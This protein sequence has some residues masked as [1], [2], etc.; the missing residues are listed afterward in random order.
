MASICE[1]QLKKYTRIPL[2]NTQ[3]DVDLG[4]IIG[5]FPLYWFIGI[6]QFVWPVL[7]LW[8]VIKII[9]LKKNKLSFPNLLLMFVLFIV[10]QII[11]SIS[12]LFSEELYTWFAFFRNLATFITG[13]FVLFIV[14]NAVQEWEQ[15]KRLIM[16]AT[17]VFGLTALVGMLAIV[18]LLRFNFYSP[19]SSIFPS[20][21]M[22]SSVGGR[23]SL[24]SLGISATLFSFKYYR[25]TTFFSFP[26]L[27]ATTLLPLI[28]LA[29]YT[30]KISKKRFQKILMV[31]AIIFMGINLLFTTSRAATASLIA[32]F[33]YMQV[34]VKKRRK[35]LR[36]SV[37]VSAV[38]VGLIIVVLNSALVDAFKD[39]IAFRSTNT[40]FSL[41][42]TTLNYW[43][44]LPIF[45]WATARRME[46]TGIY[47]PLGSHSYYLAILFRFGLLGSITF[48]LKYVLLWTGTRPFKEK[49]FKDQALAQMDDL[50]Q[51][52]RWIVVALIID[53]FATI[54]ITDMSTMV[55]VWLTFGL[56]YVTRRIASRKK[57]EAQNQ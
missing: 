45:G 49:Q 50:L 53:G 46:E 31:I 30:F 3:P 48:I 2:I 37:V 51:D 43:L 32:G 4:I 52:G 54:P 8:V 11:S 15:V 35:F 1:N 28:P 17:S 25:L 18:G 19:A 47:L 55:F 7:L 6:D 22:E 20:W 41:Y 39:L 40:R 26:T 16:T 23:F 5:L 56:L 33:V 12:A 38:L 27:Y 42:L 57:C 21:L 29:F 34:V 44:E 9:I 13:V 10:F 24:R 36:W 14:V